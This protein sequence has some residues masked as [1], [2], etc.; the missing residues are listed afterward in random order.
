[1][2]NR[3]RWILHAEGAA[4][5]GV[6]VFFYARG[7]FGWGLYALLFLAPDLSMLGYL[8]NV[9]VGATLYNLVHTSTIPL[10]G[11]VAV[12]ALPQPSLLRFLLIWLS[13]IGLDRM[14]GF[15]LKYSTQFRDT[16]LQRV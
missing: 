13:H 7:H 10:L 15:G 14:L 5:L 12:M 6:S 8:V 11:L 1:M 2:L 3:P 4:I 16:H 9:R